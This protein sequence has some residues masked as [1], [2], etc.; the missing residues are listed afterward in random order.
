M[1]AA[2]SMKLGI[3]GGGRAAWAFGSGWT[4]AGRPLSGISLR[5]DS[6]SRV[7]E[8]LAT[9][10]LPLEELAA[11]SDLLLLAAGDSDLEGL[12]RHVSTLASGGTILF[13]PSGSLPSSIFGDLTASFSLHPLRSLP[14]PGE[15]VTFEGTLLVFEGPPALAELAR[16]ICAAL[17]GRFASIP[18]EAK[19]LYHAAAVLGSNHVAALLEASV[20]L[21]ASVGIAEGDLRPAVEALARSA[22][23][24]W[25]GGTGEGRFT[26]P[27][28]RR[29]SGT[30][31]Q[32]LEALAAKDPA[33]ANLYRL[34][35]RELARAVE[36]AGGNDTE[37]TR[38]IDL[39]RDPTIS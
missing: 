29:E 33:R 36:K 15:P 35:G 16:E 1:I 32:H 38:I 13:H 31:E 26:G 37:L 11:R 27:I 18:P 23:G 30:V 19:T 34:L 7:P 8:L 12:A 22:I 3:I 25:A 28:A 39:L 2:S 5:P 14:A 20:D 4:A 21:L 6:P 24:N 9:P 17:G 10:R